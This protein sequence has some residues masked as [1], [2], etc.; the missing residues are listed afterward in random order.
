M[1]K[2]LTV[3]MLLGLAALMGLALGLGVALIAAISRRAGAGAGTLLIGC[4]ALVAVLCVRTRCR[5]ARAVA[6]VRG[7]AS[8]ASRP[9]LV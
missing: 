3:G 8:P 7:E 4:A 9:S 5:S 2:S 1:M 6:R